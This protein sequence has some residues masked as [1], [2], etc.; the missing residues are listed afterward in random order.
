[1]EEV[2]DDIIIARCMLV[3]RG[4]FGTANVPDV[5][6]L[7]DWARTQG[8][9]KPLPPSKYQKKIVWKKIT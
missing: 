7:P 4:I 6:M 9:F 1:M 2:S 3:L 8:W 5:S